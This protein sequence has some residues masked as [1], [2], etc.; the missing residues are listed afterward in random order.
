MKSN[1]AIILI[2][3]SIALFY[4]FTGNQYQEAKALYR[5]AGEYQNILKNISAI[6]ELRDRLLV[7]YEALPQVEIDR[8]NKIL[9]DNIDTVRLAFDLDQIASRYGIAISRIRVETNASINPQLISLPS[10]GPYDKVLISFSFVSNYSNFMRFLLDLERNL[11]IMDIIQVSFQSN[12]TG[13]YEYKVAAE[14][15]WLK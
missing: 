15:Y 4:L 6:S 13:L 9:P 7:T 3:L 2:L 11:R 5:L 8:I 14:T 12:E 1:S 10:S